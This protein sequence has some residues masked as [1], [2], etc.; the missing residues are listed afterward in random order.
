LKHN[1]LFLTIFVRRGG[2]LAIFLLY[3]QV[4]YGGGR[5]RILMVI[6]L[7]KGW[8]WKYSRARVRMIHK[9]RLLGWV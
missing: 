3:L 4:T 1:Y 8:W 7:V 9:P 2:I 6:I 5:E